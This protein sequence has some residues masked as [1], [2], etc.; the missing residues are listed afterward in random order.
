MTETA[1]VAQMNNTIFWAL[2]WFGLL[3]C[4]VIQFIDRNYK[5]SIELIGFQRD[6]D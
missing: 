3:V 5:N 2:A 4:F 6:F 1:I